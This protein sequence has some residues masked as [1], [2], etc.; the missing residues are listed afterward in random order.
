MTKVLK[1]LVS[2]I[3]TPILLLVSFVVG[4]IN[5]M[6]IMAG[7]CAGMFVSILLKD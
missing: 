1:F 5:T 4:G 7:L 6:Y 2:L 3:I